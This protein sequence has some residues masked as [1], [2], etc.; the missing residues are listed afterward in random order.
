[1]RSDYEKT[2]ARY[3]ELEKKYK[4]AL[5]DLEYVEDRVL[6]QQ[7]IIARY[8]LEIASKDRE[9]VELSYLVSKGLENDRDRN[10]N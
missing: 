6:E 4:E 7:D 3:N 5:R 8:K 1:M 2:L 10:A 9:I